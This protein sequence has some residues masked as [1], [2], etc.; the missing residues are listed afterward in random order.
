[1]HF[2]IFFTVIARGCCEVSFLARLI[3]K[4]PR[5]SP[6]RFY[7]LEICNRLTID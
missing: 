4:N 2:S 7:R 5:V 6:A 1:M 3:E